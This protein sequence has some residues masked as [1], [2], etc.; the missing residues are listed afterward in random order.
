LIRIAILAPLAT[1]CACAT[2]VTFKNQSDTWVNVRVYVAD[3]AERAD[4]GWPF[5]ATGTM[6]VAPGRTASYALA[7]NPK[8]KEGGR[9][10]IHVLVEP[11]T[12]TWETPPSYWLE[13]LT[14]PP[15][16]IVSGG[17]RSS[18]QFTSENG[19]V[20]PIPEPLAT[21]GTFVRLMTEPV[22]PAKEA[23][24]PP[25]EAAAGEAAA[26]EPSAP[27]PGAP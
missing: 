18:L 19:M 6:Q 10:V 7:E 9:P 24:P 13:C 12:P 15:I 23:P 17:G 5:A 14:P 8:Y 25:K 26:E 21:G 22:G 1:L 3:P 2:G 4:T 16:T 20:A 11:A 27:P